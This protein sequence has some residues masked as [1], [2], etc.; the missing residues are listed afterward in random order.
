MIIGIYAKLEQ[1]YYYGYY[2]QHRDVPGDVQGN[3]AKETMPEFWC[4]QAR[5]AYHA[6]VSIID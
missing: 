4:K 2:A 3:K 6:A 1:E 5:D